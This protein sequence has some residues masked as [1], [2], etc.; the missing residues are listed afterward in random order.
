T[1]TQWRA[2]CEAFGLGDLA[3]DAT[4]ATNP[5]RVAARDRMLPRLRDVFGKLTRDEVAEICERSAVG[6]APITRP[7]ELFG[8]P[9]L[10]QPGAMIELM[11]AD[12]RVMPIP[13]LPLEMNGERFGKRL[14]I[15]HAGEH[16]ADVARE[17]GCDAD[18]IRT[19]VEDGV[20]GVAGEGVS[21]AKA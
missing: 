13:A 9:Q 19:L 6:Y 7:D 8:N 21:L 14:D 3:A 11:L 1:D 16:S 10:Q 17:L 15:P 12:G 18:E 20:L 4:L 5:Q 2:F